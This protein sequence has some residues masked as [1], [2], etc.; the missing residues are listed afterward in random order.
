VVGAN[1]NGKTTLLRIMAGLLAPTSGSAVTGHNV[2]VAY[3]GQH[4]AAHMDTRSTVFEQVWQSS[5]VEDVSHV[6]TALG[7]MLFSG[8]DTDKAVGVLSGGEKARVA[9]AKLLVSPGNLM[10][11]DEPTN[12]LDLDASEALARALESFEG[13]LVFVSHNRSFVGRL[14]TRVWNVEGRRVEEFP[15]TFEEY[16]DHCLRVARGDVSG[17]IAAEAPA[18][19]VGSTKPTPVMRPSRRPATSKRALARRIEELE[20][21][22][23]QLETAQTERGKE[24]STPETYSDQALYQRLLDEYRRDAA[25]LEELIARWEHAQGE[26]LALSTVEP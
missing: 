5:A 1:G 20:T 11:L 8:D 6:R 25:K 17:A 23:A 15:G 18:G 19:R 13:T 26:L 16:L 4:V 2:R 7:T 22:I 9:L 3:H 12:H 10:L 24:L 14:A 21:R